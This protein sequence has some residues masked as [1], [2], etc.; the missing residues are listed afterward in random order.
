MEALRRYLYAENFP[1]LA[2]MQ[3][4]AQKNERRP[5]RLSDVEEPGDLLRGTNIGNSHAKELVAGI[6]VLLYSRGVHFKELEGLVVRHI[7]RQRI[8]GKQELKTGVV[9]GYDGAR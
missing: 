2:A 5:V 3:P 9:R 8:G 4:L 7:H 1:V 6:P